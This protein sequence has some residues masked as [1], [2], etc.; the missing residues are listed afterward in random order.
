MDLD[1]G[2]LPAQISGRCQLVKTGQD[3]SDPEL[4]IFVNGKLQAVTQA[5]PFDG[6]TFSAIV[7]PDSL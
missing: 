1:S 2:F 3:P 4:A 5:M 7:P 6:G